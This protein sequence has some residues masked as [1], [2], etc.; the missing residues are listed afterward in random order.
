MNGSLA[1][2]LNYQRAMSRSVAV[3]VWA[4]ALAAA[5]PGQARAEEVVA[6]KSAEPGDLELG[7]DLST[8]RF[9]TAHQTFY[10]L[11]LNPTIARR[12]GRGIS[13]IGAVPLSGGWTP[14]SSCCRMS[15]GNLTAGARY[16]QRLSDELTFWGESSVSAPT[17]G[18]DGDQG[19]NSAYSATV[20]MSRDAG[21]Y[22]PGTTTLRLGTGVAYQRARWFISSFAAGHVWLTDGDGLVGNRVVIPLALRAGWRYSERTS[23]ISGLRSVLNPKADDPL[24]ASAETGI[25][26]IRGNVTYE[27][28]IAMALDRASRE[29]DIISFI[30][31]MQWRI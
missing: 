26:H 28:R 19:R 22:L 13:I 27:G 5:M 23:W 9:G 11:T 15:L 18:S 31:T 14:N 30:G 25:R 7:V 21:F 29:L 4:C 20:E 3:V 10:Q 24:A 17:S 8:T 2:R 6:E 16:Q 12:L 1:C